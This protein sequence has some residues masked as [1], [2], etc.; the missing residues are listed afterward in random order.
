MVQL[1]TYVIRQTNSK[2]IPFTLDVIAALNIADHKFSNVLLNFERSK[3]ATEQ[4]RAEQ[5]M[6]FDTFAYV[7]CDG[8][9]FSYFPLHS[10]TTFRLGARFTVHRNNF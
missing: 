4:M 2:C 10:V 1:W 9:Q 6:Y 5:K 7:D 8:W 3:F